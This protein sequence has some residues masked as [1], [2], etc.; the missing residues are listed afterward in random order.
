METEMEMIGACAVRSALAVDSLGAGGQL[1]GGTVR[2]S[3]ESTQES[4]LIQFVRSYPLFS[5]LVPSDPPDGL[6]HG[7]SSD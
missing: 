1:F 5:V 2:Q 3:S 4:R 7:C 6:S